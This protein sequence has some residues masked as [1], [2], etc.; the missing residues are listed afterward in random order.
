M[1]TKWDSK[2]LAKTK[3]PN[4]SSWWYDMY[5]WM[6][7]KIKGWNMVYTPEEVDFLVKETQRTTRSPGKRQAIMEYWEL[8]AMEEIG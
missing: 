2:E 3:Y 8:R 5:A 7:H 4:K 1:T 6:V